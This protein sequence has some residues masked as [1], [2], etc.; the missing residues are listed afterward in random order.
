MGD[1]GTQFGKLIEGYK[2]WGNEY[3]LTENPI[4]KLMQIYVRISALCKEDESV[5]EKCRE[6]FKLLEQND[7]YCVKLWKEFKKIS[8]EEFQKIYDLLRN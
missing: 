1:Y 5:L 2:R 6:N 7:E 8:L 4:E 3:D